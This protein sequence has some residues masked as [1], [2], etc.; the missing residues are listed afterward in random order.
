MGIQTSID[1]IPSVD[2]ENPERFE[3]SND[4][5]IDIATNTGELNIVNEETEIASASKSAAIKT[6]NDLKPAVVSHKEYDESRNR[7]IATMTD[8]AYCDDGIAPS[9]YVTAKTEIVKTVALICPEMAADSVEI[10]PSNTE[11]STGETSLTCAIDLEIENIL[12]YETNVID[13]VSNVIES[14]ESGNAIE[15]KATGSETQP[16]NDSVANSSVIDSTTKMPAD[17][18]K[19]CSV[20]AATQT[21]F[22]EEADIVSDIAASIGAAS[23]TTSFIASTITADVNSEE[24]TSDNSQRRNS[25]EANLTRDIAATQRPAT[26]S[27]DN[28]QCDEILEDV[29][30]VAV[31]AEVA[32]TTFLNEEDDDSGL[33]VAIEAVDNDDKCEELLSIARLRY[34]GQ[35]M[36]QETENDIEKREFVDKCAVVDDSECTRF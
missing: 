32:Q 10:L 27:R 11:K 2:I 36:I 28:E 22:C 19:H 31:E 14:D 25:E 20:T 13:D 26:M 7:D 8:N 5:M 9:L 29:Q 24:T 33:D 34:E 15:N 23:A 12:N 6:E 1:E 30:L 18:V 16:V 21:V 4:Q 3:A 35:Q 17:F